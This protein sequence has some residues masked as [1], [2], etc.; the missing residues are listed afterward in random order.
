[1]TF[2]AVVKQ[3]TSGIFRRHM[4]IYPDTDL[5]TEIMTNIVRCMHHKDG[6][7]WTDTLQNLQTHLDMCRYN[8]IPCPNQCAARLSRIVVDDHLEFTCPRRKVTC[9]ICGQEFTGEYMEDSHSGNCPVEIVWCENKCGAKLQRRYLNNHMRN[10]CHKRLVPCRFCNKQFVFETLQSHSY[11]CPRFPIPCPNRCDPAKIPREDIEKHIENQCPSATVPCSFAQAGCKHKCPR[12]SLDQHLDANT[13][14]HLNLMQDLV[15]TQDNQLE[16]L[17]NKI[18]DLTCITDGILTWKMDDYKN[19][20]A[21][22]KAKTSHEICSE[23][24]YTSRYGYKLGATV[25]LNGN[26]SGEDKYLSLYIRLLPGEYDNLLEW[27]FRL[28]ITFTLFDQNEH[29]EKRVNIRESF[30]PDISWKHFQKP[31]KDSDALGFGYPKFISHVMLNTR[32]YIK[33]DALFIQIKVDT[34]K[35]IPM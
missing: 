17:R 20:F 3:R 12:Y 15:A 18:T 32:N 23:S 28:P 19:M 4:Q 8:A 27:P 29:F 35:V 11:N 10:E 24:F 25:F 21:T 6:C 1:M 16:S 9:D 30:L 34:S 7:K 33:D 5:Q 2:F 14:Y 31:E 26:G 13:K 22:T